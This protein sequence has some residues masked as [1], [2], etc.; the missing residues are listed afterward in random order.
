MADFLR[1]GVSEGARAVRGSHEY[2]VV[3]FVALAMAFAMEGDGKKV[4]GNSAELFRAIKE[5]LLASDTNRLVAEL[6]FVRI[7][8]LAAPTPPT[9]PVLYIEPVVALLIITNAFLLGLQTD[10]NWQDW[11]GWQLVEIVFTFI[12]CVEIG[13]RVRLAGWRTYLFGQGSSWNYF[14]IFLVISGVVDILLT[15][16]VQEES[17]AAATQLLRA[18][19]LVRLTRMF[20]VFRL[21]FIKELQLMIKGLVGGLRTLCLAFALLFVVIYVIAVFATI[22][23]GRGTHEDSVRPLF[24]NVPQSMFTAFRC[25]SGECITEGGAPI[26]PLLVNEFGAL[27]VLGYVSSYMLITMGAWAVISWPDT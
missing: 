19:R 27:F 2:N 11:A 23:I 10:E 17:E 26:A 22:A 13:V 1:G 15:S 8:D 6:T 9:D 20:R 14:D 3:P 12:F 18:C 24:I 16:V 7:N 4:F 21:K 25:F 5:I